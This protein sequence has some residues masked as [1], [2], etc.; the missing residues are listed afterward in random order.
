MR[1]FVLVFAVSALFCVIA[2]AQ[3]DSPSLGD[4]ARQVR[5]QKQK[6]SQPNGA[7][8]KDPSK[9]GSQVA[10]VI[11]NEEL[12]SHTA[13]KTAAEGLPDSKDNDSSAKD[14]ISKDSV[15]K[16]TAAK[17]STS[18]DKEKDSAKEP[19]SESAANDRDA[20][21]EQI[22]QQIQVAKQMVASFQQQID[23]LTA[24]IQYVGGN[25]VS[26]CEQWN[27][28]QQ[29]KQQQADIMKSQLEE[30]KH[31]LEEMQDAARRQGFGSSVY[32]P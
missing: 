26:N 2:S 27:E 29:R 21:A 13:P 12:P 6:D 16:E 17:D 28:A 9:A 32:E 14:S 8:A 1:K 23:E 7:V 19:G 18:K 15:A 22:K 30:A 25:C 3:D 31:R 11:T 20:K 5:A 24:S 4:L 10:H